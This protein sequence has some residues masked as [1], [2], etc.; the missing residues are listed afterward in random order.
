MSS[1]PRSDEE[2]KQQAEFLDAIYSNVPADCWSYIW[3]LGPRG[4]R[5]T[6]W[7]QTPEQAAKHC[8]DEK[9]NTYW[10]VAF[11]EEK[12]EPDQRIKVADAA[13]IIAL[14]GDLD[15]ADDENPDRPADQ[16]EAL[17]LIEKF[18]LV[19][20]AIIH[21]GHGLQCFWLLEEAWLFG[22]DDAERQ[23]AEALG[24]AWGKQ[25]QRI[26][27]EHGFTLDSVHD[28]A[29]VMRV[30]GTVNVKREPAVPVTIVEA[31]WSHRY[32]LDDVRVALGEQPNNVVNLPLPAKPDATPAGDDRSASLVERLEASVAADETIRDSWQRVRMAGGEVAPSASEWYQSICTLLAH[33]GWAH[34]ELEWV[35][36]HSHATYRDD[37]PL[38]G[39]K[40]T[41]TVDRALESV[42]K[43]RVKERA[44][45]QS[46]GN[47][48]RASGAGEKEVRAALAAAP[49]AAK[50]DVDLMVAQVM[51]VDEDDLDLGD[52]LTR[53][54]KHLRLPAVAGIIKRGHTQG[55]FELLLEDDSIITLGESGDL[56][57][58]TRLR[59]HIHDATGRVPKR[60]SEIDFDHFVEAVAD[61]AQVIET[62]TQNEETCSWISDMV[63]RYQHKELAGTS[64]VFHA[65]TAILGKNE[66]DAHG[67]NYFWWRGCLHL[68]LPSFGQFV[69]KHLGVQ[70]SQQQL[71]LRLSRL[72]F[73]SGKCAGREGEKT[74]T[75]SIWISPPGFDPSNPEKIAPTAVN[76]TTVKE[77]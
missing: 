5:T 18:P 23:A 50:V 52:P 61:C 70:S 40:I 31:D 26:A 19:P 49:E 72:G 10:S 68:H 4:G 6:Y 41:A 1:L 75:I 53:I 25:L 27:E 48:L 69:N 22:D 15:F 35:I 38:H 76:D 59:A 21:S 65:I 30:P 64:D 8:T 71:R 44:K 3:I 14:V 74:K 63:S 45:L 13:G 55:V 17:K 62:G 2:R 58:Q 7:C 39:A 24:K 43:S 20:T 77:P 34:L 54:R 32:S 36:R 28:L 29:R 56:L 57:N 33:A 11:A 37:K 67:T 60:V 51:A 66:F 73:T 9:V 16:A 42:A 12:G 47:A 46:M